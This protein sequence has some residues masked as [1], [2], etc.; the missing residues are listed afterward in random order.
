MEKI[1]TVLDFLYSMGALGCKGKYGGQGALCCSLQPS[2]LY[3]SIQFADDWNF[4]YPGVSF[5]VSGRH[6]KQLYLS[7]Y[8]SAS[9][10]VLSLKDKIFLKPQQPKRKY[11]FVM[12]RDS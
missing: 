8:Q 9:V 4:K 10:T 3:N 2:K 5:R 7:S 6:A 12:Q 1:S 11:G